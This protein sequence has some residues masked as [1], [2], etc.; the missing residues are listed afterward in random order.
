[1]SQFTRRGCLKK[2]FVG[3]D[4]LYKSAKQIGIYVHMFNHDKLT[5]PT[6]F[7]LSPPSLQRYFEVHLMTTPTCVF[8][9]VAADMGDD[10]TDC[11]YGKV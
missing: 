2:L 8:L 6:G 1:M 5:T 10:K 4:T 11:K 3:L 9:G 7:S